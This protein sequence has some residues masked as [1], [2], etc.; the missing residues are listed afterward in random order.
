M[1]ISNVTEETSIAGTGQSGGRG[2][3][4]S[5]LGSLS[6]TRQE[7]KELI[8]L[9]AGNALPVEP[10]RDVVSTD[11]TFAGTRRGDGRAELL[12]TESNGKG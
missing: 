7:K 3:A 6:E 10:D 8:L 9:A 11:K 1:K 5:P 2:V 12:R 4:S